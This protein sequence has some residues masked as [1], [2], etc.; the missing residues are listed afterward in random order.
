MNENN[1]T[2]EKVVEEEK[3]A[4]PINKVKEDIKE[5]LNQP[6]QAPSIQIDSFIRLSLILVLSALLIFIVWQFMIKPTIDF[7]NNE[8]KVEDAARRYY[9]FNYSQ[10]PTGER[11]AT[12][13][14]QQLYDKAFLTEDLYIPNSTKP[15]DSQNSWVKVRKENGEYK[16]YT[17]LKCGIQESNIDHEG[18]VIEING[19]KEMTIGLGEEYKEPGVKSVVDDK[20]G[21]LDVKD[22]VI[23]SSALN[24]NEIGEYEV[25]YIATDNL[26]N[27]TVVK[28][29]VKVIAK[30]KSIVAKETNK[31]NYYKGKDP[32]NYVYFSG[33]LW[34][35]V[36]SDGKNVRLVA[37]EDIANVNYA[38]LNK[39]LSYFYNHL[40]DGAKKLIVKNKYCNEL[41]ESVNEK[42]DECNSY[43]KKLNSYVLSVADVNK[44]NTEEGNYLITE[45]ISWLSNEKS[46][47]EA[48]TVDVFTYADSK[49]YLEDKK[50]YNYGVRPVITIKGDSLIKSGLGTY[51]SPYNLGE[52]PPGK[53]DDKI[54]TR[55]SGEFIKHAGMLWRIVEVNKDGTTK[56]ISMD[57]I[58]AKDNVKVKTSYQS[59]S[60]IYNPTEKGNIGY[61]IKN[62]VSEYV[63]TSYFVNKNVEVPI[64]DGEIQ[65]GKET[66][67]KKYKVKL[68][69]PNIYEMFSA[70][71]NT[72]GNMKAHWLINSSKQDV[73]KSAM[74]DIGVIITIVGDYDEFG[75]RVVANLQENIMITKGKGT[76]DN[77]YNITK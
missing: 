57:S 22:V 71:T 39:W 51:K 55:T 42:I 19:D 28:R 37:F 14:I 17:Y 10:L 77:P 21:K 56:I 73:T 61:F 63:D 70:Y 36:D 13:S 1:N 31:E 27:K 24:T 48:Y 26:S 7:K 50:T 4:N 45:T 49:S 72:F 38:G 54:N 16:Y 30:L 53:V 40:S 15:C 25:Q 47:E 18:P 76:F 35:I 8:K 23:K 59:K 65:Y 2:E 5:V 43:T 20:D 67:T 29:K 34:R 60:K 32:N 41:L 6:E 3:P 33:M 75:I 74:T 69:A 44:A 68:S 52:T 46:D 9:E 58:K 12:L 11:V 66:T 62:K 64:Y